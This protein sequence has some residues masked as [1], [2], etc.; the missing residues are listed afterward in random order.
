[1][2]VR[3]LT[4][5]QIEASERLMDMLGPG[6]ADLCPVDAFLAMCPDCGQRLVVVQMSNPGVY[7]LYNAGLSVSNYLPVLRMHFYKERIPKPFIYL[8]NGARGEGGGL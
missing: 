2:D 1:M 6:L 7:F 5:S 3:L 8:P 4:T